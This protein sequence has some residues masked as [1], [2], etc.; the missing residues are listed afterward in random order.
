MSPI[1]QEI[2]RAVFADSEYLKK[3]VLT[4]AHMFNKDDPAYFSSNFASAMNVRYFP[5]LIVNLNKN[6]QIYAA[7]ASVKSAVTKL[8]DYRLAV[9][10]LEDD[11]YGIQSGSPFA[12]S[13]R[14]FA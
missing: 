6:N 7:N 10:I 11:I 4:S 12:D 2:Y 5:T 8:K 3:A 14:I 13:R 1:M 9:W